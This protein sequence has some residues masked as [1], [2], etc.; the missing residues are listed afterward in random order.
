ML[1]FSALSTNRPVQSC[2]MPGSG[3]AVR[4][5]G[6][7]PRRRFGARRSN[8]AWKPGNCALVNG[9]Q[10]FAPP[11]VQMICAPSHCTVK[12]TAG[13]PYQPEDDAALSASPYGEPREGRVP[14]TE[15]S[16]RIGEPPR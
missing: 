14:I 9:Y 8:T 1:Q 12:S 4:N 5:G 13:N 2:T 15:A 7:K 10:P 6:A 11:Y 3:T 16:A